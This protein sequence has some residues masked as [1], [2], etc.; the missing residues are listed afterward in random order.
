MK[1]REW[2]FDVA[3]LPLIVFSTLQQYLIWTENFGGVRYLKSIADSHEFRPYVY[4]VLVPL[5][6]RLLE[7][8]TGLAAYQ[9]LNPLVVLAAVGLYFVLKRLLIEALRL[10]NPQQASFLTF[11]YL[12]AFLMSLMVFAKVHDVP[13]ALLFTLAFLLLY[14]GNFLG[15]ILLFPIV[16]LN[17][18]TSFLLIMF[19]LAWG[20][21]M[22]RDGY[23][24][25][26]YIVLLLYQVVIYLGIRIVII[27]TFAYLP[28]EV[29]QW[30]VH[31]NYVTFTS[32][33]LITLPLFL[34]FVTLVYVIWKGFPHVPAFFQVAVSTVFPLQVLLYL[35]L[36]FSWELRVFAES[37][38]II[39]VLFT[40]GIQA[41]YATRVNRLDTQLEFRPRG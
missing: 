34:G 27:K 26:R 19:W 22:V 40:S 14:R 9:W 36:G 2:F 25:A 32:H 16:T 1:K 28:G 6:A 7:K 10:H 41:I 18:E 24:V 38:P 21:R 3:L 20:Y 5:L 4:R 8:I 23:P 15:Y 33:P 37:L 17:R 12:E 35:T 11:L 13:T 30:N 39:A 29:F 31:K